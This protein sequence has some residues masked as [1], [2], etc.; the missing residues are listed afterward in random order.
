MSRKKE[1]GPIP[2]ALAFTVHRTEILSDNKTGQLALCVAPTPSLL[3]DPVNNKAGDF[4]VTTE[5]RKSLATTCFN[6]DTTTVSVT[7]TIALRNS[8]IYAKNQG[9][10]KIEVEGD[11]KLVI[12]VV[13]GVSSPL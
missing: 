12:D 4:I 2:R 7:K 1:E 10:A 11:S 13:N 6:F 9:L 5:T 3:L 8:L